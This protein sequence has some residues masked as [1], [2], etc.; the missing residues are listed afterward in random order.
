[1]LVLVF[2]VSRLGLIP[3]IPRV[4]SML[5]FWQKHSRYFLSFELL[6]PTLMSYHDGRLRDSIQK[7][8]YDRQ[9]CSR[10]LIE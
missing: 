7:E 6:V 3:L 1:M 10:I 2:R 5:N 8:V 9:P 4:F